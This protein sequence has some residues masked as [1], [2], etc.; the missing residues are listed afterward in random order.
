M[1]RASSCPSSGA[2]QL[3]Q[4]PLVY[5]RNLMIA[6]LLVV[7]GPVDQTT[8]GFRKILNIKFNENSSSERWVVP[9]GQTD[10]Q[11][12]GNTDV[13]T[14][15]VAFRNSAHLPRNTCLYLTLVFT[16]HLSLS[17]TCLYLTLVFTL[18]LSLPYTCLYLTIVFTLQLSLPYTC[19]YLTLVFTFHLSLSYTCLYLNLFAGCAVLCEPQSAT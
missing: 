1:F 9:R 6:V 5:N 3:Q 2:Q 11:M 18:H 17:Y 13:M 7:V 15:I 8:T 19:L 16:L 4:Q 14:L 12:D 10:R